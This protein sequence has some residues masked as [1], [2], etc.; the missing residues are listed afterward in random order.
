[1][2]ILSV[3]GEHSDYSL[4]KLKSIAVLLTASHVCLS[5]E[6][7]NVSFSATVTYVEWVQTLTSLSEWL[8]S[9]SMTVLSLH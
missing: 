4:Q 9:I 8:F 1:M 2:F 5:I 7:L 3:Q 6:D